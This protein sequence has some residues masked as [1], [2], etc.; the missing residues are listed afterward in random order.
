M[1]NKRILFVDDDRDVLEIYA[2][3]LSFHFSVVKTD[4]AT[5]ALEILKKAPPFAVVISD[6]YMP[7]MDG[8]TFLKEIQKIHP[9][10]IRMLLTGTGDIGAAIDAINNGN[11]FR[12]LTKP[13]D[14]TLLI[15]TV[16]DAIEQYRLVTSENDILRRTLQ[17]SIDMLLEI[18]SLI[19]PE[20]FNRSHHIKKIAGT[21]AR[22]LNLDNIWEIELAAL[23]SHI[24]YAILPPK[25]LDKIK[26]KETLTE[27]ENLILQDHPKLAR[28]LLK[29]IP[30]LEVIAESINFQFTRYYKNK[31]QV[32]PPNVLQ[33]TRIL[34]IAIDFHR[35]KQEGLSS[36]QALSQLT[37]EDHKYEQ[38][39]LDA[40][41]QGIEHEKNTLI[42]RSLS[43]SE[44][45]PG[46]ILNEDLENAENYLFIP[47]GT[48]IT[49]VLKLQLVNLRKYNKISDPIEMLCTDID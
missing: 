40:L 36:R 33:I 43:V 7:E 14:T 37:R 15:K 5:K 28:K 32:I 2:R 44:I 49:R 13:V 1:I 46:M 29:N 3:L 23:F 6:Y 31:N 45:V 17:G 48:E 20:I 25:I 27:H 26:K 10:T 34:K 39:Y 4:S 35:W 47:K 24:G 11:I 16:N 30:R 22:E 21:I 18:L 42:T 38:I 19:N 12:F 41:E 8:G 9:Q